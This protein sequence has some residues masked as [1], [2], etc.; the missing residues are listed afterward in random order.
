MYLGHKLYLDNTLSN[1]DFLLCHFSEKKD[2]LSVY[3]ENFKGTDVR[4]QIKF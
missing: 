1:E 4:F 2:I 3:E